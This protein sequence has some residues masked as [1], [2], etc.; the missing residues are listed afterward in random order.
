M[1]KSFMRGDLSAATPRVTYVKFYTSWYFVF[2]IVLQSFLEPIL[3]AADACKENNFTT[4]ALHK[5]LQVGHG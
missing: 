2:A 3:I 1:H 4:Q 5:L